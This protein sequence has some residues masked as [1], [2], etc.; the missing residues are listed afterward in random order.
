MREV[1]TSTRELI[2]AM[3][4]TLHAADPPGIGLAAPQVGVSKQII[5]VDIGQ[6]P[7]V[8]VNPRILARKGRQSGKEGCLCVPGLY[9][10]VERAEWVRVKGLNKEGKPVEYEGHEILARVFQH[11]IDHLHG[12]LFIDRVKNW[13]DIETTEYF[14]ISP[15]LEKII[16]GETI[17]STR[18]S[19]SRA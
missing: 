13:E 2:E 9:A 18:G 4:E 12:V 17:V 7:I 11:E 6:G 16:K 14:Q 3:I 5:V 8:L 19:A 10:E 1:D 15:E